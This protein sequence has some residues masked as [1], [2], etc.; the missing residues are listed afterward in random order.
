MKKE[1]PSKQAV[2]PTK[3]ES[4]K[5]D[6]KGGSIR[7]S[8]YLQL[9]PLFN[10]YQEYQDYL[11][12]N[13]NALTG[14]KEHEQID[15]YRNKVIRQWKRSQETIETL[16]SA[17]N[18]K[19]DKTIFRDILSEYYHLFKKQIHFPEIKRTLEFYIKEGQKKPRN[20]ISKEEK[21]FL[22][23]KDEIN[24]TSF[25]KFVRDLSARDLDYSNS[26]YSRLWN[27]YYSG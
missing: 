2:I 5:G 16:H 1:K 13:F 21:A 18:E 15:F 9:K 6:S 3:N 17:N 10:H 19:K 22:K 23:I 25:G 7:M 14:S 27:K 12:S 26:T 4:N 20:R 24:P 11:Q 8:L